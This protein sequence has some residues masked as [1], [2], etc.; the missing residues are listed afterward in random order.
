V[1][2]EVCYR[3]FVSKFIFVFLVL[4]FQNAPLAAAGTLACLITKNN[5]NPFFIKIRE[6]AESSAKEAGLDIHAY[7]GEKDG[8]AA[9]QISA[10]ENC[11]ADGAKGILITPSNDS[12]GPALKAA[13]ATGVLVIALDAPLGDADAVDAT[14]TTDWAAVTAKLDS[15]IGS[16]ASISMAVTKS[17]GDGSVD[18]STI[19]NLFGKDSIKNT[20]LNFGDFSS[21]FVESLRRSAVGSDTV[22]VSVNGS[23]QSVSAVDSGDVKATII[24]NPQLMSKVGIEKIT[25]FASTGEKP[26]GNI[27][28]NTS[29]FASSKDGGGSDIDVSTAKSLCFEGGDFGSN[30]FVWIGGKESGD[31]CPTCPT[32]GACPASIILAEA[33]CCPKNGACPQ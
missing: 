5:T 19:E 7:A 26:T 24:S 27:Y 12:V 16:Q 23:C 15:Y 13:R 4:L 33:Q 14:I 21:Q 31:G 32:S 29:L 28:V 25:Q 2:A 20:I 6:G 1:E 17:G 9:P 30:E 8:D 3:Q 11:V 22:L 10:I 18:L